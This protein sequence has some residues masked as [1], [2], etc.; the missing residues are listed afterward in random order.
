M[1]AAREKERTDGM[2]GQGQLK[3]EVGVEEVFDAGRRMAEAYAEMRRLE[4]V[5]EGV[6]NEHK[7][8]MMNLEDAVRKCAMF[9][10]GTTVGAD[11][12]PEG[13]AQ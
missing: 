10:N 3:L 11:A 9:I 5:F 8:K 6:K 7:R 2:D 1:V 12:A 13:G 4:R